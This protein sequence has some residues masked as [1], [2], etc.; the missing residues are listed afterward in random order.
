[1]QGASYGSFSPEPDDL[2]C[3]P[4]RALASCWP[5]GR[6]EFSARGASRI[7]V[8]ALVLLTAVRL[9]SGSLAGS[10]PVAAEGTGPVL[11]GVPPAAPAPP[12]RKLTSWR[13]TDGW[14]MAVPPHDETLRYDVRYGVFGSIGAL[15]VSSGGLASRPGAAPTV[16][17][18]GVG[19]GSVLGLG[20]MHNQID[21]EFDSWYRGSRRWTSARGDA[22]ARTVDTGAWDGGQ[23]HLARRKPGAAD[24]TY[25]FRASVQTS[26]PLGLIWRLR[27]TP[28]PLRG[29]DVIQVVDGLA[30]YRVRVTT[31]AAADPVP[32]AAPGVTA[33]R[34][35]GE[36]TPYFYD[37]RPDPDRTTRHFTMWLDP[38]A[39]HLPLRITLP[40]GPADVV[41][42]LVD[43]RVGLR[44]GAGQVGA[45]APGARSL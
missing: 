9:A 1:M 26:D 30:M 10:L 22:G 27:T 39:G 12:P 6:G 40:F 15:Q 41:L 43:A 38:R 7:R 24:E 13:R 36:V 45:P 14:K 16:R 11:T 8:N 33:L 23:A 29:T 35:E 28:P 2:R 3:S 44:A 42:R 18:Q 21:A 4:R 5:C 19:G 31:V 25:N 37:G 17:L 32:E 34:L 20:S